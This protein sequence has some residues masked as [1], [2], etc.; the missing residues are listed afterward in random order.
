MFRALVAARLTDVSANL[1]TAVPATRSA[2]P[3]NSGLCWVAPCMN[4]L[5]RAFCP[6]GPRW[7]RSVPVGWPPAFPVR[8]CRGKSS[9][10]STGFGC[11]LRPRWWS[12]STPGSLT[13]PLPALHRRL[14]SS[15]RHRPR[16][17]GSAA[18]SF[19]ETSVGRVSRFRSKRSSRLPMRCWLARSSQPTRMSPAPLCPHGGRRAQSAAP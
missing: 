13:W 19:T 4:A 7:K 17:R 10:W 9:N 5:F 16:T 18:V 12:A 15:G 11:W 14:R 3:K 2:G 8:S 1:F 6:G